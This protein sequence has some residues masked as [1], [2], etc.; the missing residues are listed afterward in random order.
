MQRISVVLLVIML[1]A[2]GV[3]SSNAAA[4]YPDHQ[5]R[6]IVPYPPAG[7]ND[8][9]A[10]AL[11][12]F[13]TRRLGQT[14]IVEN[15]PGANGILAA[16]FVSRAAPDG[17]T[18]FMA[19][20]GSHGI[21]PA[22]YRELRYDAVKDFTPI[23]MVAS[24]PNVLV[25]PASLGI[26][27]LKGLIAYGRAH[28]GDLSY[29]SNGTGSSQQMAGAMFAHAFHLDML[30]VPYKGTGPMMTDLL[31]G[32]IKMSFINV[33]PIMPHVRDGK[34]VPLAIADETRLSLLPQV[35]AVATLAPGFS[36]GVWWALVG[37]ARM[38]ADIQN[39]LNQAARAFTEAPA[40]RDLLARLGAT[41]R[42]SSPAE[43]QAFIEAEVRKWR[44]VAQEAKLEPQ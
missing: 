42:G 14:V 8:T 12:E 44:K 10:R 13:M 4:A 37:P 19:N 7:G 6:L 34:L 40:T 29:G 3:A 27:D 25:V 23:S 33:V 32:R 43:L 24:S 17:Y 35:P 5:I 30:H 15:R 9:T 41:P 2:L 11:A 16:E 39:T 20:V 36:A 26:R 18:L 22:I 21:N 1:M 28:P 31:A 38:P